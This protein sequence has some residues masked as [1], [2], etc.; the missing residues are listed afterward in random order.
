MPLLFVVLAAALA[1]L[2]VAVD[3][4][5]DGERLPT[6]VRTTVDSARDLLGTIATATITVAGVAFSISLLVVQLASN[7]YSPRVLQTFFRDAFTKRVLGIVLGV[8]TYSLLILRAVRGPIQDNGG[9][10]IPHLSVLLGLLLG[11]VAILAIVAFINHSAHS[12]SA[13]EII[14]RV[15]AE[16][17]ALIRRVH[18]ERE[19]ARSGPVP[20]VP[21]PP[22]D[23]LI[24]PAARDGWI[25]QV[26]PDELLDA[27]P[28]GGTVLLHARPGGFVAEGLP[29]CTLWPIPG[30]DEPR[31]AACR[32][33]WAAVRQGA[34]RTMQQDPE[35]GIRQLVDVALRALS[36]SANDPTTAEEVIE[37]LAAVMKELLTRDLPPRLH[38]REGGRRLFRLADPDHQG[39]VDGAYDQIR[40]AAATH[41]TVLVSLLR[42]LGPVVRFLEGAGLP[43]RAALLRR[44]AHDAVEGVEREAGLRRDA[45]A[46]RTVAERQE[47]MGAETGRRT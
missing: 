21:E 31:E 4:A 14:R 39:L 32:E 37:H 25:Q 8:F 34:S 19:E 44:K 35:F 12:M 42:S 11:V 7:Q 43:D 16:T 1:Q 5:M 46:V 33:V 38:E 24:V 2:M 17:R 26:E 40:R 3:G 41:P 18:P 22:D 45:E 36:P 20:P 10:V 47:L 28:E 9:E 23:A 30:E 13:D 29:L 27:V 6:L 15:A